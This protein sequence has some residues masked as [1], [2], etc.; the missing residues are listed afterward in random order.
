M[1]SWFKIAILILL[2]LL[3][4][5][6]AASRDVVLNLPDQLKLQANSAASEYVEIGAI[7]LVM[8]SKKAYREQGILH[9]FQYE[10]QLVG[11]DGSVVSTKTGDLLDLVDE[12][13]R[14]ALIGF[15][16]EIRSLLQQKILGR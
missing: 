11:M 16:E 9:R 5:S 7:Y 1:Q 12:V 15:M 6:S 14:T 8:V 13:D 2:S 10:V 4:C 3:Y